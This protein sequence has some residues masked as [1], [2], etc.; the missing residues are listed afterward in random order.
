MTTHNE[1]HV[2]VK[3]NSWR[4]HCF[5]PRGGEYS[6]ALEIDYLYYYVFFFLEE[7]CCKIISLYDVSCGPCGPCGPHGTHKKYLF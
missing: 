3:E 6:P 5:P 2:A 7:I 1:E 4:A